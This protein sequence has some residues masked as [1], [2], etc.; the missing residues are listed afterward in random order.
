MIGDRDCGGR[1]AG[2]PLHHD[3]A[4]STTNFDEAMMGKDGADLATRED[5][6]FTHE[7]RSAG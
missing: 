7:R 4:A 3:V 5:A 2:T 6:Q 1:P